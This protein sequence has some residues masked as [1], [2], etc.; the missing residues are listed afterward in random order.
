MGTLFVFKFGGVL[1]DFI[2][3]M[4]FVL[5]SVNTC[6]CSVAL[7]CYSIMIEFHK[8]LTALKFSVYKM[9]C[10]ELNIGDISFSL[11]LYVKFPV[12]LCTKAMD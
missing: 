12:S 4:C 6:L 7:V 9:N 3:F 1:S 2:S 11:Q 10:C 8:T 5:L